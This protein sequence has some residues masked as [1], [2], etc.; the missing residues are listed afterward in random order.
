MS[1][2]IVKIPTLPGRTDGL[3]VD[4]THVYEVLGRISEVGSLSPMKAPELMSTFNKAYLV[5]GKYLNV[6]RLEEINAVAALNK[7]KS[8]LVLDE[9][10]TK[11]K[12]KHLKDTKSNI[13]AMME[14][15]SDYVQIKDVVEQLAALQELLKHHLKSLEMGYTGAKKQIG[16]HNP[17]LNNRQSE[18]NGADEANR[19]LGFNSKARLDTYFGDIK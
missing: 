1:N 7:R 3:E 15:D 4:L 13:D 9:I 10:P 18:L 2:L 17:N 19:R 14:T 8:I 6:V 16:E 5:L 12:E 11:L